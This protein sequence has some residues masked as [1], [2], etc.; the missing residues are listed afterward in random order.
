[1]L[2]T[3]AMS[4][5]SL[6]FSV[7]AMYG[8]AFMT[9]ACLYIGY[10]SYLKW[11]D[12]GERVKQNEHKKKERKKEPSTT[13]KDNPRVPDIEDFGKSLIPKTMKQMKADGLIPYTVEERKEKIVELNGLPYPNFMS[14]VIKSGQR[15]ARE[16][17]LVFQANIGLYCNQACT[18]C[19]VDSSPSR[20]EM[21]SRETTDRCLEVIRNSP[22]VKIVDLTGGAPELNKEFRYWVAECRKLGLHIIDRCNLTVLLEPKQSDLCQFLADNEVHVIASLPC[23]LEDNV[24]G[25]RGDEVFRR[26]VA[27]LRMLN[28]RGYGVDDDGDGTSSLRLDLVYNPTGV[29]LPPPQ[30]E[31]EAAYKKHLGEKYGIYFDRLICVTNVPINRF[32]DHLK[33]PYSIE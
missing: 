25:Q 14:K 13:I 7:G 3:I 30:E 9:L 10:K 2:D 19:H 1:M 22:S 16:S 23:Y 29:H 27:A 32:H 6:V 5:A 21:M 15:M 24:D 20:K 17:C 12:S 11:C 4:L 28:E 26:S 18:H 8:A 33:G 31:L